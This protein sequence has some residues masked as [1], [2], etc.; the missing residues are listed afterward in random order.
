MVHN[1]TTIHQIMN[2][3]ARIPGLRS[4]EVDMGLSDTINTIDALIYEKWVSVLKSDLTVLQHSKLPR[5]HMFRGE[6]FLFARFF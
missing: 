6:R 4:F 2:S 1:G 3:L 5:K